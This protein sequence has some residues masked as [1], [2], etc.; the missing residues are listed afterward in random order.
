MRFPF[1]MM[2]NP[3]IH[4]CRVRGVQLYEM[5]CVM[6]EVR[7]N[8]TV[9]QTPD[10]L[11]FVPQRYFITY[12]IP[13]GQTRGQHAH[14]CCTQFLVCAHGQCHVRVDDGTA[15]EDIHLDR[16]TL[17]VLVPPLV[18]AE[19]DRHSPD[20]ALLVLA[21]QPY[22]PDDYIRDYDEFLTMIRRTTTRP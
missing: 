21:S 8:L 4:P 11:P 6:D 19:E 2:T 10:G 3:Q 5:P 9:G 17:G 1:L 12:G 15:Q 7:G 16:P 13:E 14:K 18:W 20:S 22:E